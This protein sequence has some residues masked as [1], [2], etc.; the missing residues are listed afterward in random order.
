MSKAACERRI[1][2]IQS[3]MEANKIDIMVLIDR[4]NLIYFADIEQAECMAIVIPREGSAEGATLSLDLAW[5]QLNCTLDQVRGYHFPSQTLAGAIVDIIKEKGYHDPV[6]GFERYFVGFAVFDILRNAFNQNK[7]VNASELIYRQRAIKDLEEIEK[8]RMA[9][10]AVC[11]GLEAALK[12]IEPGVREIDI[13]AEAE[14]AAMKAGSQGTPF[15]T[16]IVSGHKT[17]ITH[18]FSDSKVVKEGEIVLIHIGAKYQG[19]IAK[20]CRTVAVGTIPEEQKK[21]YQV[22]KESQ[23][24]GIEAMKPGVPSYQVDMACRKVVN[25]YGYGDELFLD[26]IGY[27]MGLRQSEFY[28]MIG[29]PFPYPLQANMVVDILLPSIY[30]PLVGGPRLTDTILINHNGA[31]ILTDFSRDLIQK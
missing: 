24:A 31:E 26:I 18:P 30:K 6:I 27:G 2:S 29:K 4:E 23:S 10:K 12:V 16:Q 22:L 13:A 9:S 25:S 14:Y 5:V 19:Y 15:R 7:F 17:M 1:K 11:A 8:I 3:A 20:L 21:I 28:P